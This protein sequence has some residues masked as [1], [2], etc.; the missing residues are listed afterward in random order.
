M[1]D[2][3]K[4]TTKADFSQFKT[5]AL[6]LQEELGLMHYSLYFE[7]KDLKCDREGDRI[8]AACDVSE[9]GKCAAL[10]LTDRYH[11]S[12]D[13]DNDLNP[14]GLAQHEVFHLLTHKL[15]W[16]GKSRYLGSTDLEEETEATIVRLENFMKKYKRRRP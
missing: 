12:F 16:L 15:I 1:K 4:K 3:L 8:I 5:E 11:T 10:A 14:V 9:I 7:L 2:K 6:R 13:S